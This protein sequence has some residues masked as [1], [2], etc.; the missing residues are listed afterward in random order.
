MWNNIKT[1]FQKAFVDKPEQVIEEPISVKETP[2]K[3]PEKKKSTLKKK[4]PAATNLGS[5]SVIKKAKKQ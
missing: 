5:N 2:K 1:F 3:A 4:E